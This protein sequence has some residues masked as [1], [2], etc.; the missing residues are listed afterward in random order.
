[1]IL[2]CYLN[3]Y[4]GNDLTERIIIRSD[5]FLTNDMVKYS[6]VIIKCLPN[7]IYNKISNLIRITVV[8]VTW[9]VLYEGFYQVY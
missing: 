8:F 1:M 5:T 7:Q 9:N 3:I 4:R 6:L 2:I